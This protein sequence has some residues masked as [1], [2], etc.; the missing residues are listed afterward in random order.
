[1]ECVIY[2]MLHLVA[3]VCWNLQDHYWRRTYLERG[4]EDLHTLLWSVKLIVWVHARGLGGC[5]RIILKLI[6]REQEVKMEWIRL[7]VVNFFM[8]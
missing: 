6:F 7:S 5:D 1:M 8:L 4:E 2:N 3:F